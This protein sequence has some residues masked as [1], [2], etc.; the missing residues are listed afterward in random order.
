[1]PQLRDCARLSEHF[2]I[3]E[4]LHSPPATRRGIDRAPPAYV[5]ERL[6]RLAVEV[7]EPTRHRFGPMMITS[8]WRPS[9]LNKA[10]GGAKESAH[11]ALEDDS[12]E[13]CASDLQPLRAA[14]EEVFDWLRLQSGL[15]FDLII[16]E[17]GKA[18]DSEMDDCIH[19][20]G[21]KHPR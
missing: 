2:S 20:Q 16:L 4:F 9:A 15:P 1:M 14:V 13:K 12:E 11:Q 6:R 18:K 7:L 5:I 21:A 10:V 8:G 19:V 3:G 17:R